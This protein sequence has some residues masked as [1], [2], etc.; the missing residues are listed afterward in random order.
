MKESEY[1]MVRDLSRLDIA[2]LALGAIVP[3]GSVG[4]DVKEY[5]EVMLRLQAFQDALYAKINIEP[6]DPIDSTP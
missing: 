5:R 3:D 6:V 1:I 4:I 2:I